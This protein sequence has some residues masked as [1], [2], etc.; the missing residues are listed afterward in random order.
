MPLTT[1]ADLYAASDALA[2]WFNSQELDPCNSTAVMMLTIARGMVRVTRDETALLDGVEI[3]SDMLVA[4][5][6]E[7][8]CK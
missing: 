5:I 8:L 7:C 6:A 4:S 3:H 2:R 1:D